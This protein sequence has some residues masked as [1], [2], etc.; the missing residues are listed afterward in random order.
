MVER[1]SDAVLESLSAYVADHIG[2]HFPENRWPDLGQGLIAAAR[3]FHMESAEACG[4]WI[5]STEL[6]QEQI[7]TLASH[8]TVGET[9]FFRDKKSIEIL[10]Q[11]ILPELIAHRSGGDR[12]LRVWSAGC[13]T[14]EE[15]YSVA[16]LLAQMIP[17]LSRWNISIL[18]TDINLPAIQTASEGIYGE[19]SFRDTPQPIKERNFTQIRKSK[20]QIRPEI[21]R[22]VTFSY[23]NLAEEVD[24]S[25]E[26]NTGAMDL[27]MCR[28]V[29]MYFV[30]RKI[31][32]VVDRFHRALLT[33]GWL[34]VS[35]CEASQSVFSQFET[36]DFMDAIIYRKSPSQKPYSLVAN[37]SVWEQTLET[38]NVP[39]SPT[40]TSENDSSSPSPHSLHSNNTLPPSEADLLSLAQTLYKDGRFE[41]AEDIAMQHLG[42]GRE[43]PEAYALLA[44]I[45][46]DQNR[47]AESLSWCEKAIESG[48]LNPAY[49]Y[50][51]AT[52]LE[53]IGDAAQSVRHLRQVLYLNPQ[54]VL[55][56]FALGNHLRMAGQEKRAM[57]H[58][59][60]A[61]SL[62]E[63]Y[64]ADKTI[65]D[66]EGL[67]AGRLVEIIESTMSFGSS[68]H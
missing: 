11:K 23:L 14:G 53:E 44:R 21:K 52:V 36:A 56:H 42:K 61:I 66:S 62:L 41:Q 68:A 3:D 1:V 26:S 55:A 7:G 34:L 19:W 16:I 67:T 59:R 54:H 12:R 25:A 10:E 15:P 60:N 24:L 45:C 29:L 13:C 31:P 37:E 18:G 33:N 50:L 28:N 2:L 46:A 39:E 43:E 20:W 65:P 51:A 30:P 22:L 32:P 9:Y 49:R 17:D 58:F 63:R 47:L 40:H 6:S 35:P 48:T 8:L 27:I 64:P 57:I 5:I 4:H 38:Q